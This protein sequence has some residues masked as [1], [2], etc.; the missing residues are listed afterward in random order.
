MGFAPFPQAAAVLPNLLSPQVSAEL[1]I[2]AVAALT[3]QSDPGVA[4]MLIAAW[5]NLGPKLHREVIDGL[6][7]KTDWLSELFAAI[8]ARQIGAGE[9]DRDVKQLLMNHPNPKV[10]DRARS[11]FAADRPGNV[12]ATLAA[13]RPAL[14]RTTRADRGRAI[15]ERRCATCHRVGDFGH[16]VGP[17]LASVQNKS[18][19]DLLVAILD[20]NREAQPNYISYTLV[21]HQGIVHTGIIVAESAAGVTLRRADA[22]ED[23]DPAHRD[24]RAGLDGEVT[25][26]RGARQGHHPERDGRPDRVHQVA[27]TRA[28]QV[29][30]SATRRATSLREALRPNALAALWEPSATSGT[31]CFFSSST[32][33][34]RSPSS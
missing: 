5:R 24:R 29:A 23:R 17:D 2:E 9:I 32:W 18:P 22:K 27:S 26:A 28:A 11:V 15:Y 8:E 10:R 7:R 14:E 21:T 1:Q 3:N 30:P 34:R 12:T 6:V 19:A 20:P 25:D 31:R 33:S 16:A 13:Y 4:R